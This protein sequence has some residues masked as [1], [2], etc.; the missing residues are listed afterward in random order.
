LIRISDRRQL[1]KLQQRA[2]AWLASDPQTE[3][4]GE[5]LWQELMAVTS[6]LMQINGRSELVEH[7]RRVLQEVC[8]EL[9]FRNASPESLWPGLA[10]LR[11]LD[12]SLDRLLDGRR[13]T[14][15]QAWQEVVCRL[16]DVHLAATVD[17]DDAAMEP[18]LAATARG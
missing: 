6:L 13:T 9:R 12:L 4:E 16:A 5:H 18:Q 1:R 15:A 14:E 11:G 17:A 3:S 2:R 10:S 7:D 8:A